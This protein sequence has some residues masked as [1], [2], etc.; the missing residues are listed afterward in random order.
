MG[1][2]I[3]GS[4]VYMTGDDDPF[5][6]T[7]PADVVVQKLE[8]ADQIRFYALPGKWT[9]RRTKEEHERT[10]YIRPGEVKAVCPLIYDPDFVPEDDDE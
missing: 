4:N 5:M 7:M 9:N 6:C 1:I 8:E 3:D 10:F 2:A